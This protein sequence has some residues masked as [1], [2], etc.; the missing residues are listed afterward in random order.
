MNAQYC[1]VVISRA[2]PGI[3]KGGS[4]GG[5]GIELTEVSRWDSGTK[6]KSEIWRKK[7]PEADE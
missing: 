6:P 3:G 2:D 4:S 1:L 5:L 7:F